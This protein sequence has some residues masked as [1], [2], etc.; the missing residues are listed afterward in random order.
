M[1]VYIIAS[2]LIS[3]ILTGMLSVGGGLVT[4]SLL[5]ALPFFIGGA[6]LSMQEIAAMVAMQTCVAMFTSSMVYFRRGEFVWEAL[7]IM[8]LPAF[9]GSIMGAITS[10]RLSSHSLTVVYACLATMATLSLT[11]KIFGEKRRG[12]PI[13]HLFQ[14]VGL[15]SWMGP[16]LEIFIT[17]AIAFLA[18]LVGITGGFIFVPY[19]GLFYQHDV[20]RITGTALIVQLFAA[21]GNILARLV[22]NLGLPLL[23]LYL[24]VGAV[25]G[26][27]FGA[28]FSGWMS[29]P[30]LNWLSTILLAVIVLHTW[31]VVF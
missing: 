8:A 13:S 11:F 7:Q 18:G 4:I 24:V 6:A 5:L 20:R 29:L 23:G 28:R 9:L 22:L 16:V 25:L 19:I 15:P 10:H 26:G 31:Y 17:F 14:L 27:Y 1:V 2:G 30:M 3:G 12:R 21:V